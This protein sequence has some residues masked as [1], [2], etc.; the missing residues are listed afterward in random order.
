MKF[1]TATEAAAAAGFSKSTLRR[2]VKAGRFPQPVKL[3][4]GRRGYIESELQAWLAARLAERT[5]TLKRPG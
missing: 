5:A 4:K 1:R 3:S 2:E